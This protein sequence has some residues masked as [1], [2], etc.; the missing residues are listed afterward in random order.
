MSTM[1][2]RGKSGSRVVASAGKACRRSVDRGRGR[3]SSQWHR[4]HGG[5]LRHLIAEETGCHHIDWFVESFAELASQADERERAPSP[6]VE[7]HH[8]VDVAVGPVVA[9]RDRAEHPHVRHAGL[10]R[11]LL[12]LV[13]T[14]A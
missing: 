12:D 14:R 6:H 4:F 8:Y 1:S 3:H 13:A 7:V 5:P 2:Y 9:A 10:P 11:Q